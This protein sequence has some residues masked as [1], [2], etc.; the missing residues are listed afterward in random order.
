MGLSTK[1][2]V[3]KQLPLLQHTTL[4]VSFPATFLCTSQ[5]YLVYI[6]NP[7]LAEHIRNVVH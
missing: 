1:T 4:S 2:T 5:D 3:P 6:H 7:P